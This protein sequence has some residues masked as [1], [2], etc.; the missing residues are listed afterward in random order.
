MN[1]VFIKGESSENIL[2]LDFIQ[3]HQL[4]Y[5]NDTQQLSFLHT[6]SKALF[7]LKKNMILS[8]SSAIMQARSF[9]KICQNMNYV[10]NIYA[11]KTMLI[12]G[13]S[14]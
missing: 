3:K 11:P 1:N 7:T 2:G 6:P 14:S 4:H 9:K 8:L 5:N 13:P 10:A 12:L